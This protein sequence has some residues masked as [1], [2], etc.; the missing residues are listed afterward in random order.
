MSKTTIQNLIIAAIG[1]MLITGLIIGSRFL[2]IEFPEYEGELDFIRF[3]GVSAII[4][5]SA[6][7]ALANAGEL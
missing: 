2:M 6:L 5:I 3:F 7:S 4:I 1:M